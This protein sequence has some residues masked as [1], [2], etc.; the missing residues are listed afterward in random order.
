MKT[1]FLK[2]LFVFFVSI[3]IGC[4]SKQE[5]SQKITEKNNKE[6]KKVNCNDDNLSEE[7]DEVCTAPCCSEK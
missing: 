6:S 2:I 1:N 4:E 3:L 5:S 7:K